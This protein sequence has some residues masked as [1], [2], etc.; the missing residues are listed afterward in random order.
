VSALDAITARIAREGPIRFDAFMELALYGDGGFFSGGAGA[1]RRADFITSPEVGPLFGAVLARTID[2]EWERLGR[3]D[4][5]VVVEGGAGRG[6]LAS[7]VLG[8]SPACAPALRYVCVERSARLRS[9]AESA[10]PV[11]PAENVFGA[12]VG[13]DLDEERVVL[14]TGPV[15]AVLDDLPLVP[16]TGMVIANELL[17]NLP[18]RLF[19]RVERGWA[20]VLVALGDDGGLVEL[21]VDAAPDDAEEAARSAPDAPAGGRIPLQHGAATWVRSAL[22]IVRRGR[23][24]LVDY[25]DTTPALAARPWTEW[26]RTYRGHQRGGSPLDAPGEQDITCEVAVDQLR[27]PPVDRSQA[28]FLRAHG[29]DDLAAAAREAWSARAHIGDLEAIRARS[30]AGEADALTDP[31]GLGAFRVLEW[32]VGS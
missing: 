17:D 8:A 32:V 31:S 24:V 28:E 10:L 1:G 6:A 4:P 16:I 2:A 11:E 23:I 30:R 5:F 29:V 21:L 15:V 26:L 3:P 25:A 9:E 18:V 12:V 14:G 13:G 7:A 20:E 19:E 27:P 22:E